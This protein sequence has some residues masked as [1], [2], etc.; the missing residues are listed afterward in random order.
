MR[1]SL[2]PWRPALIVFTSIA[3]CAVAPGVARAQLQEDLFDDTQL[4]DVRLVVNSQDWQTLK[5]LADENTYYPADMTWKNVTVRNIGIRSRGSGTRNGIKPGLRVDFNRYL[6]DQTLLGLKAVLLD[7][8]YTDPTTI[9][10]SVA[11]KMY[12]GIGLPA[13]REAHVRLYVNNDYVG[14]YTIVESV[15]R[16]FIT[17]LFGTAE[18]NTEL[19]GFLFEYKWR[20]YWYLDYLGSDL[21]PYASL[22]KPQTRD[23]AAISTIYS[24]I[25]GMVRAIN[26]ASDDDFVE[27]VA[28]Y[29]DLTEF[30]KF[31]AVEQFTTE[32]DGFAG[33]WATNNFYLYRFRQNNIAQLIPWD[34]DHAFTFIDV[35]VTFRLDQNVLTRR[36]MAVPALRQVFFDTLLQLADMADATDPND[37]RGWLEREL[38]RQYS[39]IATAL[40]ADPY[41]P[42]SMDDAV[43]DADFLRQFGHGRSTFVRCDV[44]RTQDPSLEE[45][46]TVP[47]PTT[48]STIASARTMSRNTTARAKTS[49]S[50][51]Q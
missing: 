49:Y 42:F 31:L 43:A 36:A 4:Q 34:R 40:A 20:F 15:D 2:R 41:L 50:R 11:M 24:P 21:Q 19:G 44:A 6:T 28:K 13:P 17:R 47:L 3:L 33:N 35:P 48:D 22:F 23:T 46:C 25:E 45:N 10:E 16:T 5:T 26:D 8:A 9:R 38:D 14:V 39:L 30:M 7:N 1:H 37:P 32:W 29:L 51:H 27:T 12:A 18:G